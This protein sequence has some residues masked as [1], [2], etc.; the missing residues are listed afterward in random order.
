[1]ETRTN[2][3]TELKISVA[4][5]C[6]GKT[7]DEMDF[8]CDFYTSQA[9]VV[10]VEKAVMI[11]QEDGTYVAIVDTTGMASGT[12]QMKA[13]AQIPDADC[14]DGVRIEVS[15]IDTEIEVYKQ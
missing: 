13:T 7:M 10:R 8:V 5:S 4:L 12:I 6:G 9:K 14:P 11:R 3:G 15:T 2:T 1:M